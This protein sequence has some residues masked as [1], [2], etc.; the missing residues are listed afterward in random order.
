MSDLEKAGVTIVEAPLRVGFDQEARSRPRE[1]ASGH[2]R[3]RSL[4]RRRL[5]RGEDDEITPVG[6]NTVPIEYRTL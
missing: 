1:R 4:S 5:S 3:I 6:N 2:A